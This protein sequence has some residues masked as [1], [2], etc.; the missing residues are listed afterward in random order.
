MRPLFIATLLLVW[1]CPA[2]KTKDAP[3][4]ECRAFGEQC[5]FS[6]G[7][8]GSCVIRD[9]CQGKDCYVCQSQH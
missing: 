6:P 7:K 2:T 8:L 9:D 3:R 4:K 1:G 5:E